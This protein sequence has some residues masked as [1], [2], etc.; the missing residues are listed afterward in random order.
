MST[1]EV[2]KVKNIEKQFFFLSFNFLSGTGTGTGT[3]AGAANCKQK[4]L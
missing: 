2:K 4:K 1:E 3:E